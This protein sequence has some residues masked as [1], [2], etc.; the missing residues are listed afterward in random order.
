MKFLKSTIAIVAL[1]AIAS[2]NAK[3]MTK[4]TATVTPANPA[5]YGR[6]LPALPTYS[7]PLPALPGKPTPKG[8]SM[9]NEFK[10]KI[11]TNDKVTEDFIKSVK[12]AKL[13]DDEKANLLGSAASVLKKSTAVNKNS[14][15]FARQQLM[16]LP[17]LPEQAEEQELNM[18]EFFYGN[19]PSQEKQDLN[20]QEFFY[21]NE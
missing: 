3:V 14:L 17:A 20:M 21:G 9:F 13:S 4:R 11:N 16:P 5:P 12:S 10:H 2:V 7:K 6:P 18:E 8:I 15:R 1:F 19:K